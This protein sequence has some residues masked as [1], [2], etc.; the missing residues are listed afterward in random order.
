MNICH[1]PFKSLSESGCPNVLARINSFVYVLSIVYDKKNE[2]VNTG[3]MN[4]QINNYL[5]LRNCI[6]KMLQELS[7]AC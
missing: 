2:T 3:I 6:D 1:T 7:D 5:H 4:L